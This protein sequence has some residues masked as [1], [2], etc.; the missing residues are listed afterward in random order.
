MS[1]YMFWWEGRGK[2]MGKD[3][4]LDIRW[5]EILSLVNRTSFTK[6]AELAHLLSDLKDSRIH[7][8][9]SL[10]ETVS[11]LTVHKTGD[12]SIRYTTYI[13][14]LSLDMGAMKA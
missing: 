14:P 7:S 13:L 3:I 1:T 9:R 8:H 5:N 12:F 10:F 6:V 2:D 4:Q 11:H